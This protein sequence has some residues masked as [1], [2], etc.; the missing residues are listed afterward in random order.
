M[1]PRLG[2]SLSK[3]RR[4]G[5]L[6]SGQELGLTMIQLEK[7]G[8]DMTKVVD[9]FPMV[10]HALPGLFAVDFVVTR[11]WHPPSH[12]SYSQ[13]VASNYVANLLPRGIR[14]L[15]KIQHHPN[16]ER[17]RWLIHSVHVL[18]HW[19]AVP[20]TLIYIELPLLTKKSYHG[21]SI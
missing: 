11:E 2:S 18:H 12:L 13:V 7:D 6:S 9:L 14:Q 4:R 19:L 17:G 10:W 5:T 3:T 15:C 20:V 16:S 1:K 21:D 8:E